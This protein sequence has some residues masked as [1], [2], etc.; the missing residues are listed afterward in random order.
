MTQ[1]I[2]EQVGVFPAVES[3]RHFVEVSSKMLRANL[4]PRSHDSALQE[5]EGTFNRIGVDVADYVDVLAVIDGFVSVAEFAECPW[6]GREIIGH[7]HIYI[8][9]NVLADIF[10][11]SA[12]LRVCGMEESKVAISLTDSDN[13]LLL[14]LGDFLASSENFATNI[15]FVH[16]NRSVEHLFIHFHHCSADA[17]A[18][19]PRR[20]IADSKSAL[21]LASAHPFLRFT[22]KQRREKPFRQRQVRVIEDGP[23]HDAEL[24][25]A[26][27]A[28][29]EGLF[30]FKL[31]GGK[32]AAQAVDTFGPAQTSEHLPALLIGREH[33]VDIN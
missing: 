26:S 19:I 4:V 18:E 24:I 7:N 21:N 29:V 20:L 28:V 23:C 12:L 33:G 22:E 25:V 32:F 14:S 16:F 13:N 15:G 3:E 9:G 31:D 5:R 6:I 2:Q 1:G 17:M 30:S 11:E 10:C 8:F 27:L